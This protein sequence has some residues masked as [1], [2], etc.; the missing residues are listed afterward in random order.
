MISF[1]RCAVVCIAAGL[2]LAGTSFAQTV[3]FKL[4]TVSPDG[5]ATM[6]DLRETLADI[7]TKTDGRV[8]FRLYPGGV[9]GD[10]TAVLRKMRIGQLQGGILQTGAFEVF[11]SSIGIYNLPM[12]FENLKEVT[13]VR[14]KLDPKVINSLKQRNL[15][16]LGF[17][18]SGFANAM[19]KHAAT[20]IEGTRK[21]KVWSPKG[22]EGTRRLL[23]AFG[24]RPTPLSPIDVLTGLQTGLI[25]TVAGPPVLLIALQWHT[26]LK[27]RLDLPFMYIYS[28]F[29]VDSKSFN[30]LSKADQA[31]LRSSI[32]QLLR[33]AEEQ[34]YADHARALEALEIQGIET[35]NP[36]DSEAEEWRLAATSAAVEWVEAGRLDK[37]LVEELNAELEIY[38]TQHAQ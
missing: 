17:V 37:G 34:N 36:N 23:Q 21:L 1:K 4:A 7:E 12:V 33:R 2:F 9:M 24:I 22:D 18:G 3:S 25:D 16:V 31:L 10:D 8:D 5:S 29:V 11:D 38:R 32:T 20:G 35:L 19:S 27:F 6:K 15:T 14:A 30:R 28:V 26:Q 13:A